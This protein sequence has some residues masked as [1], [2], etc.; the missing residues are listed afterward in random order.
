[1]N[2]NTLRKDSG[3]CDIYPSRV[4]DSARI[5]QRQDPVVYGSAADGPLDGAQLASYDGKGYLC[6]DGLLSTEEIAVFLEELERLRASDLV[7]HAPEAVVEPASRD[8]RSVF[9]VHK[10]NRILAG[11]CTHPKVVAIARQ[12]LG[13][14]VYIHQSRINYKPGFRGKEFYWHSDFETW[15]V[16]D[17]VPRMRM[18]SCSISL[19]P[20][21]PTNGPLMIIP[22][23][24]R[25]YVSC[26]GTTPEDNYQQSLKRQEIGVPDD[27]T[28]ADLVERHGID[29]M[30]GAAGSATFF[31][32][33]VMHG[34]NSNITPL[35]RSNVF[36][37][38][39]SVS[40]TPV[41]PFCGLPPRPPFIAE[42]EDFTPV[43]DH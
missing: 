12:L 22:G 40:N 39:N 27:A 18:V 29:T 4:L 33:N 31:E 8:L 24:H 35:P 3:E 34:S 6:I 23:S 7:K 10:L 1:M 2:S 26:V 30:L 13:D 38:F 21:T 37:V 43:G 14:E 16:E 20:N 9:A 42:R 19:T 5:I 15:H 41:E 25:E 36:V 17:G 32:C 11:L 28:L